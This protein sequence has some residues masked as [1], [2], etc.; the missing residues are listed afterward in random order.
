MLS[1]NSSRLG[2]E[3]QNIDGKP[4]LCVHSLGFEL[5]VPNS[6]LVFPI[7]NLL[8]FLLSGVSYLGSTWETGVILL[9]K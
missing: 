9:H 5:T 7:K 6:I 2:G 4:P 1:R 3:S 8:Y